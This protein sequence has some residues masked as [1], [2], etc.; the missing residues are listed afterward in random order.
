MN[1][2]SLPRQPEHREKLLDLSNGKVLKTG[3][4][5]GENTT[6]TDGG[7]SAVSVIHV[8]PIGENWEVE[9]QTGTLGQAESKAEA[10]ELAIR[11]AS[12]AGI[13]KVAIHGSDGIVEKEIQVWKGTKSA[14]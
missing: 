14:D 2:S 4:L 6:N 1:E 11:L 13:G 7:W 10:E 12:D 5:G 3:E 8:N 9:N